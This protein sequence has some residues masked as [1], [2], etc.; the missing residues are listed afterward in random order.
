MGE[1]P[2]APCRSEPGAGVRTGFRRSQVWA[3]ADQRRKRPGLPGRQGHPAVRGRELHARGPTGN[4]PAG[5]P[6]QGATVCDRSTRFAAVGDAARG[7]AHTMTAEP[8]FLYDDSSSLDPLGDAEKESEQGTK[9]NF[10]KVGS[11]RP[12]SLLYTYGPGAVMDLPQ[13]T[14]MPAGL[15]D[16]D[17]IWARRDGI[18]TI[19]APRLRD[20]VRL[21]LKSP[22]A[23]LRPFPWQPK[24][25]SM[26]TDGDDLGVPARVFPQWVRCTR[27]RH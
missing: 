15:D 12:S 8:T 10:A 20:V 1:A 26:S 2:R 16:W 5:Q 3:A 19:H 9:R 17:R 27:V 14:I 13:F 24:K 23:Q 18:P 4:Q 11:G 22:N 25:I 21:M 7:G 6:G